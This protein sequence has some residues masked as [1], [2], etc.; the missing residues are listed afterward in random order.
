MTLDW[1]GWWDQAHPAT[2]PAEAASDDR[3]CTAHNAKTGAPCKAWAIA[4]GRVC[5]GHGGRAPQVR[6]AAAQRH[7]EQQAME[8]ARRT[9]PQEDLARYADP[10]SALEF[11]VSQSYRMAER[12]TGLVDELPDNQLRWAGKT[13]EHIRGEVVALQKAL[14]S[15]RMTAEGTLK[16]GLAER[17]QRLHEKQVAA[18]LDAMNAGLAKAGLAPAQ[19]QAVRAEVSRRLR[20]IQG[21]TG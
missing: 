17:R 5:A 15:L 21:G 6:E 10:F 14:D 20:L 18:I 19:E 13:G 8:L 7:Q 12:L 4:G 2:E 16:L 3:R 9:L 1:Q 11:A